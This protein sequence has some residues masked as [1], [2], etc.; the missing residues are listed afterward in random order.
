[1]HWDWA[2]L[3]VSLRALS[4]LSEQNIS[5]VPEFDTFVIFLYFQSF[6]T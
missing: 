5:N 3:Y 6:R 2:N 4:W 1:M